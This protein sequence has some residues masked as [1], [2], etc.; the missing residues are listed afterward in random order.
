MPIELELTIAEINARLQRNNAYLARAEIERLLEPL[1][2]DSKRLE[3]YGFKVYSQGD[4]DGIIEEICRRL[5]IVEG[6]FVEIGVE[7]GLEC[8]TLYLIHKGW[9][10]AWIEGNAA[11]APAIEAKFGALLQS[12][13][14]VSL[15]MVTAENID[16]VLREVGATD[17]LDLLSID[18][19]GNDIYLLEALTLRPKIIVIEYNAKF[20]GNLVKQSVYDPERVWQG[21]DYVGSSVKAIARAAAAKGYRL[22]ATNIAGVNAFF[23]RDDLAGDHFCD[24]AS[25]E[26]LYNPPR[27]W[28]LFDHFFNIGHRADFGPYLDLRDG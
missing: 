9:R 24:D 22:V 11:H 28:L 21:T 16:R 7:H 8:N 18:I 26:H 23:V 1:R 27:Y 10:G 19:D 14:Q 15:D 3:P 13:L 12:R 5:E 2:A 4:E 20:P 17:D 25:A 6:R